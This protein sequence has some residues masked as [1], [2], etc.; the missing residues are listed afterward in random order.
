MDFPLGLRLAFR[1]A[2][3]INWKYAF[4][5]FLP[6]HIATNMGIYMRVRWVCAAFVGKERQRG[7]DGVSSFLHGPCFVSHDGILGYYFLPLFRKRQKIPVPL[8]AYLC[9]FIK[10]EPEILKAA[11]WGIP[12]IPSFTRLAVKAEFRFI[13]L[14][15]KLRKVLSLLQ[16]RL[17][18]QGREFIK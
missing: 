8:H 14:E 6:S 16:I 12:R 3:I 18:S 13:C 2:Q 1:S 5:S 11:L 10:W 4:F 17:C 15:L 7:S 9:H